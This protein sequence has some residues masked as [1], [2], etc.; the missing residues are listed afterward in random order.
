[1][2]TNMLKAYVR[3]LDEIKGDD[4]QHRFV[5]SR[6]RSGGALD[7]RS[8]KEVLALGCRSADDF[9]LALHLVES[10]CALHGLINSASH[11]RVLALHR[12]AFPN[13][14]LAS[15]F[16]FTNK[17]SSVAAASYFL[18]SIRVTSTKI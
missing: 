4:S 16:Y 13:S 18:T 5:T 11:S 9:P 12:A 2:A 3:Q 7:F 1:M 10:E 14:F 17:G 8:L 6:R 15:L